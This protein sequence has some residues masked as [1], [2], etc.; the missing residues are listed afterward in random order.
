MALRAGDRGPKAVPFSV[1]CGSTPPASVLQLR[2]RVEQPDGTEVEWT[3]VSIT[4]ASGSTI[5]AQF[6]LAADGSSL[7]MPG[8]YLLRAW[9]YGTGGALLFE[10]QEVIVIVG[11]ASIG[12]PS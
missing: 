6:V 11:P 12:W 10:T 8:Q 3:P 7:P 5:T 4:S 1:S 9:A 2:V